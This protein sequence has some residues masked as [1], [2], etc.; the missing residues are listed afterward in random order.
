MQSAAINLP[1]A[2]SLFEKFEGKAHHPQFFEQTLYCLMSSAWGRGGALPPTYEINWGYLRSPGAICRHYV[3]AFKHDLLYIEGATVLFFSLLQKLFSDFLR[4]AFSSFRG[5]AASILILA[6]LLGAIGWVSH[7]PIVSGWKKLFADNPFQA[8]QARSGLERTRAKL[9]SGGPFTIAFLGGSI[10]QNAETEGFIAALRERISS[11]FPDLD[12]K[13]INAGMASTDSSWGAKRIDRDV[14]EHKPDLVFVEFAVNDGDR[15]SSPD[16]ERIVRKIHEVDPE[17]EIVFLYT[18]SDSAFRKLL[19]G[20]LPHAIAE[21]EKVAAHYGIPSVV[22]GS[23][24]A[25]KIQSGEWQCSDFSA[26]ACH[27]TKAGYESYSR[28][29]L[30]AWTELL[31]TERTSRQRFPDPLSEP[32]EMRPPKVVASPQP[33]AAPL[34]DAQGNPSLEAE[35]LPIISREW[36]DSPV[37]LSPLGSTWKIEGAVFRHMPDSER[38]LT[39]EAHWSSARWFEEARAFTGERSRALLEASPN[40]N[41]LWIAPHVAPGSV[42]VPQ[43]RWVAGKSGHYL[44]EVTSSRV[45]GHVNGPPASAGVLVLLEKPDGRSENLATSSTGQDGSLNLRHAV[46][47]DSK[48][49]LIVRPF[50]KGYEY[51]EFK[52]FDFRL[53]LFKTPPSL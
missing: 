26:D 42:D 19:K 21:H 9:S 4:S 28:D 46:W 31:K 29:L 22:L 34:L 27:P 53:G 20:R 17:T 30:F 3:G 24:L 13:I 25:S 6:T 51:A 36:V 10:T 7:E 5:V 49:A 41:D 2:E 45:E 23:D 43:L 35:R 12:L 33:P 32:F 50:T 40:A 1:L 11:D 8:V 16:M 37:L 15:N 47:L 38:I 39:E 44:F 48:D 14:L 18:M 52:D